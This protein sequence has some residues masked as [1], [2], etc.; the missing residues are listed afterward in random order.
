ML[1][2][3]LTIGGDLRYAHMTRLAAAQSMEIAAVGL[4]ACP[5]SL[6]C[7]PPEEIA[8]AKALI[9]PNPF[10]GGLCL[11]F[12]AQPL[13][14]NDVLSAAG[15]GALILLSDAA[16]MPPALK[17][18]RVIDLSAD[19]EFVLRNAHLTAEGALSAA[20]LASERS[21]S[22]SMCLVI[23]YGRIGR[24]LSQLLHSLG[25]DAAAAARRAPVRETI[26]QD[27]ISAFS[28]DEL[29]ALLPRAHFI[30]NTAPALVLPEPLLRLIRPDAH[31]MDLASP[32]YGFDLS[33]ARGLSLSAVRENGLP[34]RYCPLSA[35]EALLDAVKRALNAHFEGGSACI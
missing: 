19:P 33:L 13:E 27:G 17:S 2:S 6:P 23:G 25:A 22:G 12:S 8:R 10:R 14:L 28:M 5:F 3:I 4:E 34:G 9:L 7:A 35:G 30:F 31:L 21:L 18:D 15:R 16:G 20:S 32:P 11:P 1:M 24:R 29:P 26:R